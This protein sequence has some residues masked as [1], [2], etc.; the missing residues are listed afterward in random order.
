[1]AFTLALLAQPPVTGVFG[2]IPSG[3][4]KAALANCAADGTVVNAITGEPI[5]RAVVAT[6]SIGIGGFA[7][8]DVQGRW[9]VTAVPCG[10]TQISAQKQGYI[11]PSSGPGGPGRAV[12]P[13]QLVDGSPTHGVKIAL[14]PQSV[15]TGKVIDENGDPIQGV[16]VQAMYSSVSEGK[17]QWQMRGG[18]QT[19]DLGE[20]RM[21]GLG[22]GKYIVC[23]HGGA[24]PGNFAQVR[25]GGRMMYQENCYPGTPDGTAASALSVLPGIENRVDFNLRPSIGVTVRGMIVGLPAGE[26]GVGLQLRRRNA[27]SLNMQPTNSV[28]LGE[29]R[30]EILGVSPGSYVLNGNV[31]RPT[32]RLSGDV[33]I[34]VGITDIDGITLGLLPGFPVMGVVRMEIK[35]GGATVQRPP[36]NI[37]LRS[38]EGLMENIGQIKWS[39]DNRSFTMPD[40]MPSRYRMEVIP[41]GTYFV[42]SVTL[43]GQSLANLDVNMQQATGPIEIVLSD[44]T[45]SVQGT[46]T[47]PEGKP[48]TGAMILLSSGGGRA[49]NAFASADGYYS[50][51]VVPPGTYKA[52]SWS[53]AQQAE[54]ANPEWLRQFGGDG[55]EVTVAAGQ[56]AKIEL[57]QTQLP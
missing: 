11:F 23:A 1:M 52:Y 33:S 48:A 10:R 30:F 29:G 41:S 31:W 43:A 22:G 9:S 2:Q 15:I 26:R 36:V 53:D 34:E 45:G 44:D 27:S 40:V 19:N 13:V 24:V 20:Y 4:A 46:L 16:Q 28:M 35:G 25:G 37:R 49:I 56:T 12:T 5:V 7:Q 39:D 50:L 6:N 57:K 32:N 21:H 55:V 51:P 17:R 47:G 18:T 42:K 54:Y 14:M 8:T 3:L 38:T